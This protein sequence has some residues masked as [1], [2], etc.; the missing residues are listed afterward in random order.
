L[1]NCLTS[2]LN[3]PTQFHSCFISYS[4]QDLPLAARLYNDL[5]D[6]GVRCCWFAPEDLKTED[7]IRTGID[8]S[9][10]LH[11]K[12]LLLLSEYSVSSDWVEQEVEKALER[13]RKE[14]KLVLFPV[15]LDDAVMQVESGWPSLLRNTRNIA[16]LRE[17]RDPDSYQKVFD[18]L[19]R[20]LKGK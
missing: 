6:K 10:R 7:R 16:D 13:E 8:E 19:L 11:D 2:L 14:K 20:D 4:S 3:E 15:R 12:V 9:I 17:W 1:I 18:K 5:Q